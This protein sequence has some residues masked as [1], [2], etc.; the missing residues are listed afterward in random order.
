M[1]MEMVHVSAA[2]EEVGLSTDVL[3]RWW[4]RGWIIGEKRRYAGSGQALMFVDVESVHRCRAVLNARPHHRGYRRIIQR[5]LVCLRC[6]VP[7][8]CDS[9]DLRCLYRRWPELREKEN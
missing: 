8:D 7:G 4:R 6:V 5:E 3:C 2:A 9:G 1:E